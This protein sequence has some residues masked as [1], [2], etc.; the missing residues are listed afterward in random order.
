MTRDRSG[1][2]RFL[3]PHDEVVCVN[4][5]KKA[6]CDESGPRGRDEHLQ[7]DRSAEHRRFP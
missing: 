2:R 1:G 7:P 6:A 3:N 4:P 5:L